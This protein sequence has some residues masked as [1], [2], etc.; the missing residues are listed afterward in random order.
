MR[1]LVTCPICLTDQHIY[2]AKVANHDFGGI[3]CVGSKTPISGVNRPK[4]NKT[5]LQ[6][7]NEGD[8]SEFQVMESLLQDMSEAGFEAHEIEQGVLFNTRAYMHARRLILLALR[9]GFPIEEIS[10]AAKEMINRAFTDIKA[11]VE[12][13]LIK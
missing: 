10:D 6:F 13:G 1:K 12:M 9:K 5:F 2:A 4:I 7:I 8:V 3:H 11:D